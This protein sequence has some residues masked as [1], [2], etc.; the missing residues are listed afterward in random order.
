MTWIIETVSGK[1]L[2]PKY[3]GYIHGAGMVLLLALMA[4]IMFNDVIRIIMK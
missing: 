3:E 4:F 2:N 1:K